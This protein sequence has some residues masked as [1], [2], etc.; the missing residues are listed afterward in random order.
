MPDQL[1]E[2]LDRLVSEGTFTTRA[3]ALLAATERLLADEE[4]LRVD[5]AIVEGYTR[6]PPAP[7]ES[8]RAR[9]AGK[10]AI[11]AEPW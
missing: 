7:S 6:I 4:R 10:R 3:A 2:R 5:R 11:T 9:T 1:T 8:A